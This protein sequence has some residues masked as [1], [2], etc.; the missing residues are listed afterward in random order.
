MR[1]DYWGDHGW[2][3][4]WGITGNFEGGPP[5]LGTGGSLGDHSWG[6]HW[7]IT[8]NFEGGH[9]QLYT[10]VYSLLLVCMFVSLCEDTLYPQPFWIKPVAQGIPMKHEKVAYRTRGH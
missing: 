10:V 7:G 1:R 5:H 2:G 6:D 8:G 3:D 9:G 4:H